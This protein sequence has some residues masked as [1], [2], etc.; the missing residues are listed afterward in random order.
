MLFLLFVLFDLFMLFVFLFFV[1]LLFCCLPHFCVF[2]LFMFVCCSVVPSLHLG[3][4]PG[5]LCAV[6]VVLSVKIVLC[7]LRCLFLFAF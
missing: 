2:V 3:C 6:Q 7:C 5:F 4:M 1:L